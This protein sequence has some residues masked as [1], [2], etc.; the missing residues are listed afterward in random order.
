MRQPDWWGELDDQW[1]TELACQ[2]LSQWWLEAMPDH[3][4][5]DCHVPRSMVPHL[6]KF[7]L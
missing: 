5:Q 7:H 6:E 3:D 1:A 2:R 4:G